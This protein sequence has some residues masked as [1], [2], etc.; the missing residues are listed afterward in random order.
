MKINFNSEL[1]KNQT[2]AVVMAPDIAFEVLQ[3]PSGESLFFSI[4]TDGV[5]Y[6]TRESIATTSGWIKRELSSALSAQFKGAAVTAKSFSVAQNAQTLAI[7]V[8]L[9]VTVAGSDHLFLSLGNANT[10]TTWTNGLAWTSMPF[11]ADAPPNPLTITSVYLMNVLTSGGAMENIFVDILSSPG[12]TLNPVDRYYITPGASQQWNA[13]YLEAEMSAG[14]ITSCLGN[15]PN[16]PLPGIYTFGTIG[17]EG[18]LI[19]T[20]Q[21]NYFKPK[22]PPVITKLSVPAGATA[23]AS[24]LNSSGTSNLFVSGSEGL[25][26]FTPSI[27]VKNEAAVIASANPLTAGASELAAST[28]GGQ[29]SVWGVNAEGTLFYV[30]CAEGSEADPTAWSNPVP[31]IE[32]V[33]DFAFFLN[34]NAGTNVLFANVDGQNLIQLSQDPATANWLQR[35]IT[36][37]GTSVDDMVEYES[38]TTHIQISDANGVA[39]P[40]A[41]VSITAASRVSVYVNSVYYVLTPSV[42]LQL[43]ADAT[44]VLTVVQETQG[45]SAVCLQVALADG[46][47]VTV[48]MNP[49]ANAQATLATVT[50]GRSLSNVVVTNSDGTT[51]PLIPSGVSSSDVDAVA[52][53]VSQFQQITSELPQD[54]TKQQPSPWTATGT[55]FTVQFTAAGIQYQERRGEGDLLRGSNPI[56]VAA[57]DFFRWAKHIID[58]IESFTIQ[59]VEGINHFFVTI[60]DEI[61]DVL[62]DCFNAVGHAVEFVFNKIKV[63]FDDLVKWLG[64]IFNWSD[65]KNTHRAMKNIL[66]QCAIRAVGQ[67]STLAADVQNTFV[68]ME[69]KLNQWATLPQVSTT[70]GSYQSSSSS[71]STSAGSPQSNWGVH[72]VKGNISQALTTFN[73]GNPDRSSFAA[74]VAKLEGIVDN[75]ITG[76]VT[77]IDQL[78]DDV[79]KPIASLTP[80]QVIKKT[81]AIILDF[82]LST[83]SNLIVSGL[84]IIE[85]VVDG[86]IALLDATIQ[87]PI[88][89]PL[90]KVISG[91]ELSFLDLVCFIA[92]IPGTIIY[93]VVVKEA[94]FTQAE[95]DAL[96][97]AQS[98]GAIQAMLTCPSQPTA[99]R[100]LLAGSKGIGG[101]HSLMDV[102]NLL[103]NVFAAF[104]ALI[105][106]IMAAVKKTESATGASRSVR[107]VAACA[108]FPYVAP[109]MVGAFSN[110]GAWYTVMND[111]ITAVAIVK[112]LADNSDTLNESMDGDGEINQTWQEKISPITESVINGFWLAPAIGNIIHSHNSTSDWLGFGAN[113]AFDLG[114]IIT[115]GSENKIVD[116]PE[117]N[118]GVFVAMEV[119]TGIYGALSL[120]MLF[121]QASGGSESA[122]AAAL[123]QS[124]KQA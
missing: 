13:H 39:T 16:Q 48:S 74:I 70:M 62:L 4:G 38:F 85:I 76:I 108:Y 107:Y 7:D 18:Q 24:A 22:I 20:P 31:L 73:T 60:G 100:V 55:S 81:V 6:L 21:Y 67:I 110:S 71:S 8:G 15:L 37:P 89:S 86:M 42:P 3:T 88:L 52:Q 121:A 105:T 63:F 41:L 92:A 10:D 109:D 87:I 104:G 66:K 77:M 53:S 1:M 49:M 122:A 95:A 79:I 103:S 115:P 57:E 54:G 35:S 116:D 78:Q 50:N 9:V 99:G 98:F 64:F 58:K 94:P 12:N 114:G 5:L 23:V 51:Q 65:I 30:Q 36:L 46:S 120:G 84:E 124:E 72:H 118:A 56:V 32:N 44:G 68:N 113:L 26:V 97:S 102:L 119:L 101:A 27:Q 33:Q 61:Y 96:A 43:N 25:S 93:K 111:V 11:D 106:V 19:F 112:T 91:D 90:Y 47:G 45:L 2:H 80:L 69:D 82:I 14:S 28:S 75:E 17:G 123:P 29:T 34:L 117:V 40:N 83:A 59:L